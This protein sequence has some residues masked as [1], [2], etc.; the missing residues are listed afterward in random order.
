MEKPNFPY[1]KVGIIS[2]QVANETFIQSH[3]KL[4]SGN[5][6]ITMN[7]LKHIKNEHGKELEQI[8]MLPLD[9][10]KFVCENFN[11][12][13]ER[14]NNGF[15]LVVDNKFTPN[16]AIIELNFS[17]N[18]KYGFWE[19]KTAEPRRSSTVKKSALIWEAAKHTSN[20]RGNHLN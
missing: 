12:I 8:G 4:Q 7:Q 11:Q 13:R 1:I 3:T 16:T 10:V 19:I 9:Y 5:I 14:K 6:F 2:T 15:L 18:V 20:G 17:L